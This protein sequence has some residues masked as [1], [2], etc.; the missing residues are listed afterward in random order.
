MD[1]NGRF[2]LEALEQRIAYDPAGNVASDRSTLVAIEDAHRLDTGV[3][4]S[5]DDG[6]RP[7]G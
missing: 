5:L 2:D 7:R 4:A 6:G 3:Y 1:V